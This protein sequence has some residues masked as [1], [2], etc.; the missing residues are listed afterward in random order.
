MSQAEGKGIG[1]QKD[2]DCTCDFNGDEVFKMALESFERYP[3]SFVKAPQAA[4]Y[5]ARKCA[6]NHSLL[7]ALRLQ[8]FMVKGWFRGQHS[9]QRIKGIDLSGQHVDSKIL[10]S[11]FAQPECRIAVLKLAKAIVTSAEDTGMIIEES[12]T[13]REIDLSYLRGIQSTDVLSA[14]LES[15]LRNV[16]LTSIRIAGTDMQIRASGATSSPPI[17]GNFLEQLGKANR[18]VRNVSIADLQLEPLSVGKLLSSCPS[19]VHLDA[20]NTTGT[21][22]DNLLQEVSKHPSL[23]SLILTKVTIDISVHFDNLV[24]LVTENQQLTQLE[25][26]FVMTQPYPAG[27]YEAIQK[28]N[29]SLTR[30]NFSAGSSVVTF[31]PDYSTLGDCPAIEEVVCK[32]L[33]TGNDVPDICTFFAKKQSTGLNAFY[34]MPGAYEN[35]IEVTSKIVDG[36]TLTRVRKLY[37]E[38]IRLFEAELELFCKLISLNLSSLKEVHLEVV[39]AE[40]LNPFWSSFKGNDSIE[41]FSLKLNSTRTENYIKN[42]AESL[43]EN[44]TMKHFCVEDLRVQALF[45]STEDW[46]SL[47]ELFARNKS[48]E[49]FKINNKRLWTKL[50]AS[51]IDAIAANSSLMQLEL[52]IYDWHKQWNI[53]LIQRRNIC[54]NSEARKMSVLAFCNNCFRKNPSHKQI[55]DAQV[56]RL[57]YTFAGDIEPWT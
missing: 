52:P 49:M 23:E 44:V 40:L 4:G 45:P 8:E 2:Q 51:L 36:L 25:A 38:N 47:L 54:L 21:D 3:M 57:A 48:F 17:V 43:F 20:S 27:F 46:N 55:F 42:M 56:L 33:M 24:A 13:L 1:E 15:C 50:P 26:L 37:L 31:K 5:A 28:H 30:I 10:R 32:R 53:Q 39:A 16:A 14:L 12:K 19:L 11:V 6:V 22:V 7:P 9:L 29:R 35:S 34:A 41:R 18:N